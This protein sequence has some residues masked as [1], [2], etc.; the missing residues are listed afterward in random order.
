MGLVVSSSWDSPDLPAREQPDVSEVTNPASTKLADEKHM[1][2]SV[3]GTL[4]LGGERH[5]RNQSYLCWNQGASKMYRLC[6]NMKHH[7][8]ISGLDVRNPTGNEEQCSD[9]LE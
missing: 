6:E 3:R 1:Y 8:V 4:P 2:Y 5:V 9:N 7:K